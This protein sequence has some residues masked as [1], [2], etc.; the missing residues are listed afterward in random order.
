MGGIFGFVDKILGTDFTGDKAKKSI[1]KATAA[2][3]GANAAA[4]E[5]IQKFGKEAAEIYERYVREGLSAYD[6]ANK[7]ASDAVAAGFPQAI[8][9]YQQ[10]G[11]DALAR[12]ERGYVEGEEAYRNQYAASQT[13]RQPYVE[14]GTQML[15][16]VPQLASALGLPGAG[17]YDVT[18]SPLYQWQM[19]Q[20]DEQ[21]AN[22]LAAMGIGNDT[23]AAYIRSKNVGQ[24][25]AQER[26]RQI[27]NLQQMAGMGMQAASTFGQPEM[28]AAGD[29]ANMNIAGGVN[30]ANLMAQNAGQVGGAQ[31]QQAA[32]QAELLNQ[33]AMARSNALSG[34]GQ[35]LA[36]IQLGMGGNVGQGQIASGQAA[37]NAG[38]SKAQMPNPV[39]QLIN[40]GLQLYG[41]GAFGGAP[42]AA[43]AAA[44]VAAA[45]RPASSYGLSFRPT[46]AG[47]QSQ[48]NWGLI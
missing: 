8:A 34:L 19:Q 9:T 38:I 14:A 28:Q 25:G 15:G 45:T 23:V 12:L 46:N 42:T 6:A 30:A 20:M 36:N 43:A 40:T 3:Q 21:L 2:A 47:Y 11:A 33:A 13:A 4:A 24:L 37:M 1:D 7:A 17:S 29:L 48:Y 26:E 18:A 22:Q 16:A 27:A 32:T 41:M 31:M 39:N 44:P 5:T 35:G 10:G